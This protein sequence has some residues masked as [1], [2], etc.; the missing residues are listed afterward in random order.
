VP[1]GRSPSADGSERLAACPAVLDEVAADDCAGPA[2]PA[3]A[4]EI[5]GPLLAQLLG[6]EAQ[7]LLHRFLGGRREV[8]EREAPMPTLG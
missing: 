5:D 3:F 4:V 7:H 1:T 6:D 8:P 2:A